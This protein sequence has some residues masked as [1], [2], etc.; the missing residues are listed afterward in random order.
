MVPFLRTPRLSHAWDKYDPGFLERSIR[1][2]VSEV[3]HSKYSYRMPAYGADAKDLLVALIE[4]D[5]DSSGPDIHAVRPS[6]PTLAPFGASLAG[7]EGYSCVSCHIWK[8]QSMA[9]PDPGAIAP[10]L[11]TVTRRINREWFDRWLN[12]PSRIPPGTPISKT[13]GRC[14]PIIFW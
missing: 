8:G 9:E 5:G 7:F 11:T 1:D 6:D 13:A 10:E 4:G 12:E 14:E 3:R 2:G